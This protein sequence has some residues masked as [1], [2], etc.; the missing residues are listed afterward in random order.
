MAL[1]F[2]FV[3]RHEVDL[4]IR[5]VRPAPHEVMAHEA[6]EV[7]RRRDAGIN[8]VIC[9]FRFRA[10]GGGNFTGGLRGAFE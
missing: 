4:R 10:D 6:V 9:Y 7:E 5:H 3:F 1:R 8:F 2:V